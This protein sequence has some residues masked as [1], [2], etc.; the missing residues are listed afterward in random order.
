MVL[1]VSFWAYDQNSI[2]ARNFSGKTESWWT[3]E[4]NNQLHEKF[5]LETDLEAVFIDSWAKQP[6]NLNDPLQQ[7]AF[8]RETLKLWNIFSNSPTFEFKTI[9]DV[10]EENI[11]MKEEIKWLNDVITNNIS[12]L[13]NQI[14]DVRDDM[15]DL[16]SHMKNVPV[17]MYFVYILIILINDSFSSPLWY[18]Y[19]IF[20]SKEPF[21]PG[22][23]TQIRTPIIQ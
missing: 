16:S 21:W 6:W 9:Q 12:D 19:T 18:H 4:M 2:Q 23:H 22:L 17:G 13:S 1:G 10:I 8:H 5:H 14:G 15:D 7:E 11:R 20:L 3:D